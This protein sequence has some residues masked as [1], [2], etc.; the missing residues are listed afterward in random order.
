MGLSLAMAR[1]LSMNAD[2]PRKADRESKGPVACVEV[3]LG[4][5]PFGGMTEIQCAVGLEPAPIC[6]AYNRSIC[7]AKRV[8]RARIRVLLNMHNIRATLA[9]F[10]SQL[11][12]GTDD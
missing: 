9:R 11:V 10:V 1:L 2:H 12:A 6:F 5:A 7:G 4:L 8:S 3:A